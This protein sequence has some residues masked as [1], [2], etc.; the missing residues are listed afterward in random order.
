MT[1]AGQKNVVNLLRCAWA[2]SQK[3]GALVWSGDINTTFRSLRNQFA[4][5]LNMGL[6][7]IPW[8][9]TDIGGFHGGD[10]N[11]PDY[12]EVFARW[13]EYGIFCPVFRL[14]GFRD[15]HIPPLSNHGGGKMLSGG[16]NEV[17][18]YGEEVYGICKKYMFI[19]ERL[20]PYI[21]GLMQATHERGTPV[22]RTLF[23][24]FPDDSQCWDVTDQYMFG[25]DLLVAP[26]ME[27][28]M[29]K[30]QVYLPAGTTWK[31]GWTGKTHHGGITITV[32][33]PLDIIPL[34]VKEGSNLPI[35]DD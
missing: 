5:G 29:T 33:A 3:Y 14:H 12:R 26:I 20:K 27:A 9:T 10:P 34:F 11:D 2:G 1:E 15:P 21:R 16:P 24:E 31:D 25:P 7:G 17:W 18:S 28:G 13:F 32:D 30:R 19:R 6:A 4:A 8:W 23:Y 35:L 22:M